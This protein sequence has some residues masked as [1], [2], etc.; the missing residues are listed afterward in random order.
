MSFRLVLCWGP[1]KHGSCFGVKN[2]KAGDWTQQLHHLHSATA[3]WLQ[4]R[5]LSIL[6]SLMM[7]LHTM[8]LLYHKQPRIGFSVVR[9]GSKTKTQRRRSWGKAG[10][11]VEQVIWGT[12]GAAALSVPTRPG[13]EERN[14]SIARDKGCSCSKRGTNPELTPSWTQVCA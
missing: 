5:Q 13:G 11:A 7:F 9:A 10:A 1:R 14:E 6:I 8:N 3:W 12:G 2:T 4:P